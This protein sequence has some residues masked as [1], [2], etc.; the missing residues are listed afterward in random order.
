MLPNMVGDLSLDG[1]PLSLLPTW[2]QDISFILLKTL[3]NL[4]NKEVGTKD[5]DLTFY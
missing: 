4:R 5:P 2:F 1:Q 3:K